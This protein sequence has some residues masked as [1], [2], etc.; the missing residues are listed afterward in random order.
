MAGD[1]C[2]SRD[3]DQGENDDCRVGGPSMADL[4]RLDVSHKVKNWADSIQ[5]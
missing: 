1:S 3:G 5:N 4:K 2:V